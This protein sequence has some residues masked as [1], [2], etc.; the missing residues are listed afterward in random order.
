MAHD[1]SG[2]QHGISREGSKK[3]LTIALI[4]TFSIMI[5]EFVGGLITNSLALL[6]DAGH[7]LSDS[8]SLVLTLV[9]IW[10]ASRP[11]SPNKTYGF[12]RFEILAAFINGI[13]L[14]LIAGWIF[15][16]AYQRIM[17]PHIVSS[18]MMIIIAVIGL[19]ANLLSAY[20]LMKKGNVEE[21]INVKSAYLHIVG[22]ALGSFGAILAGVFMLLFEW[23]IADP[24]ISVI[25]ALLIL[26]SAWGVL[27][28]TVHI[29]MEGTPITIDQ[30]KVRETLLSI[31]GVIDIHDLHI[32]TITSGL[33]SL[34][35]HLLIE[36]N[37]NEQSILQ[38]AINLI[39]NKFAIIH[40]TIQIEKTELQ[41]KE[42][43]I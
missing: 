29:L 35:C 5:L 26:K 12:Y 1:H 15:Y 30:K 3:G 41:H 40:T 6:S 4:I 16:E 22:D 17:D 33:D 9:A 32:W 11:P 8:S 34:T 43:E 39:E 23:Y 14:F 19:T 20:F 31:H 36:D 10:F 13:T 25:V 42:L 38:Q 28:T 2:H 7:M 27:R 37:E 24:I 18:G 21:N